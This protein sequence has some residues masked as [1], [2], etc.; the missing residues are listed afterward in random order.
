MKKYLS[1]TSLSATITAAVMLPAQSSASSENS[2][3][4]KKEALEE[5]VVIGTRITGPKVDIKKSITKFDQQAIQQQ[6]PTTLF[7]V[8]EDV[9]GVSI[10]GGPRASGSSISI[11][12]FSDNEDVLV[13]VDG[14][15][16]NFEKY[17][18]GSGPF[19]EPE[20]LKEISISRGA[21]GL[22]LSSG[23]LGGAIIMETKDAKDF[24]RSDSYSSSHSGTSDKLFG[25]YL[26]TGY[27]SNNKENFYSVTA[28]GTPASWLD[29]VAS[30][31]KRDSRDAR[32][33]NGDTLAKSASNPQSELIKFE[34]PGNTLTTGLSYSH[35]YTQ[36]R[37][38]FD[39]SSFSGGVNGEVLRESEDHTF[40][41]YWD[42]QPDSEQ[43]NTHFVIAYTDTS[44]LDKGINPTTSQLD[45]RVF[46]Y[47]YDI[48]N[49]ALR[50]TSH[51]NFTGGLFK[52][53]DLKI[54]IGL[55]GNTEKRTT[56]I[57]SNAN[58]T[59]QLS[60]PS[61][62]TTNWGQFLF[63]DWATGGLTTTLGIR[64]DHN[65]VEVT[66]S[67]TVALL[68]KQRLDTAVREDETLINA[69]TQYTFNA[70]PITLFYT[71]VEGIRYPKL[72]EYFT[73]GSF[74]RCRQ[75]STS[76]Q[77]ALNNLKEKK[78]QLNTSVT[79]QNNAN[80]ASI[81]TLKQ[82][83][84]TVFT[85]EINR[86]RDI[87]VSQLAAAT[88][89]ATADG[90]SAKQLEALKPENDKFINV[91]LP[92][93]LAAGLTN[94][95]AGK[96]DPIPSLIINNA[97]TI[98][99]LQDGFA[100]VLADAG[101]ND[102]SIDLDTLTVPSAKILPEPY[103]SSQI[104]GAL[105]KP[106]K[107][108]NQEIGVSYLS[109]QLFDSSDSLLLKLTY[110][111]TRVKNIL[112]SINSNPANTTDQPGTEKI[113]GVEI[114][115]GYAIGNW[116][117]DIGYSQLDGKRK[118]YHIIDNPNST[119]VLDQ[120]IIVQQIHNM[121][122][123]N[124]DELSFTVRWQSD[125]NRWGAGLRAKYQKASPALIVDPNNSNNT[126]LS[127]QDSYTE[128][129]FFANWQPYLQTDVRLTVDNM[130]NTTYRLPGGLSDEGDAVLRN[131]NRGRN[132]KLSITQYFD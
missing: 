99:G 15:L 17:R 115:A 27:A 90:A 125:D 62:K 44:V 40:S 22:M 74:S 56:L 76:G 107:A 117:Y 131:F 100:S 67:A 30:I 75:N 4:G 130:T 83:Q 89:L 103:A 7:D 113:D 85:T 101:F 54:I 3:Q 96:I 53:S 114:E 1:A 112:E 84:I 48:W 95:N 21:A 123:L 45:D 46:S 120:E 34:I 121:N 52:G 36:G 104:C 10:V 111:E 61:G 105:Y 37:E 14:A 129:T 42:Y 11:R 63:A 49:M 68:N 32:L 80:A 78:R 118:G 33:S 12:G 13:V 43:I 86:L 66:E 110:F 77:I 91:T 119:T 92:Q 128:Y 35:Y 39:A 25:A 72:D 87:R 88:I 47:D 2:D 8:I 116:R 31:T 58:T 70:L 29:V 69:G 82:Q 60:Q 41:H 19:I 59:S 64:Y 71:Y 9:P 28:Y 6:Q 122:N 81:E 38:F 51:F 57:Q 55:Q 65:T 98:Q 124:G 18:F 106:E 127:T 132:I 108:L 126:K 16:K 23:A 109:N 102:A 26:K 97:L 24:L 94:I 5:V 20:L 73:Q 79:Q 50:N 93:S